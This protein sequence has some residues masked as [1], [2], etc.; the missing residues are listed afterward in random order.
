MAL[1]T[2]R[3][4]ETSPIKLVRNIRARFQASYSHSDSM[5]WPGDEAG[6]STQNRTSLTGVVTIQES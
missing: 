2:S 6:N 5:N 3:S 1:L 4:D